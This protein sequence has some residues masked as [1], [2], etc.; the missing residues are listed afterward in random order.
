M[1]QEERILQ[2]LQTLKVRTTLSNQEIMSMFDISRDTAR[3]DIVKLVEEGVAVRTHGGIT[4]PTLM[5]EL[6]TY[7]SRVAQNLE[8]KRRLV[9]RTASYLTEGCVMF[10]DV[11]TT[12][13]ELC[14][15]IADDMNVYTHSIYNA[16]RLMEKQCEVNLLGGRLNRRNRFFGGSSVMSQLEM[17]CF[18]VAVLGAAAIH[19]DGFYFTERED[20]EVKRKVVERSNFIVVVADESKFSLSGHY[21]G[22]TFADVDV[23]ITNAMPPRSIQDAIQKAGVSL[24]I[25]DDATI[26]PRT[27]RE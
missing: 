20:A 16:E 7:H 21:R 23:L 26:T 5:S 8:V 6:Q 11:S 4:L 10:L 1:Y 14:E 15:Y 18:D 17:I 9:Q 13:E 24:D 27:G 22:A 12:V 19:E 3:R 25:W 2:I